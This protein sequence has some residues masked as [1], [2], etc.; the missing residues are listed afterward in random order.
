VESVPAIHGENGMTIIASSVL[1]LGEFART[2]RRCGGLFVSCRPDFHR[3][4]P[5]PKVNDVD[6]PTIATL[7]A[8]LT[9]DDT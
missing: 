2:A 4:V 8:K 7:L 5:H 1:F 9:L 6:E 3:I